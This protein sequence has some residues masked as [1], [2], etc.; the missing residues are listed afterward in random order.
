MFAPPTLASHANG[1]FAPSSPFRPRYP[2]AGKPTVHKK[3]RPKPPPSR[4]KRGRFGLDTAGAAPTFGAMSVARKLRRGIAYHEAGHAVV[5]WALGVRVTVCRVFYDDLKGWKGGTVANV[6]QVGQLPLPE[7]LAFFVAG[8]IAETVFQCPIP[9]DRAAD[10]DNAQIYRALM[11]EEIAEVDHRARIAEGE[12]IAREHLK[13]HWDTAIAV[14][15]RLAEC[16]YIDDASGFLKSL[17]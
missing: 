16:G 15:E 10:D 13:T 5:G 3:G 4:K 17:R 7:R 14:A 6:A 8:Y 2:R 9:H 11:D 12:D 1:V